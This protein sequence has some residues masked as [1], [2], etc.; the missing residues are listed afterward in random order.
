MT[1]FFKQK[2]GSARAD[3]RRDSNH[4]SDEALNEIEAAGSGRHVCNHQDRYH[5]HASC[6][7]SSQALP[8]DENR[9]SRVSSE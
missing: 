9:V 1:E 8:D 4:G 3:R 2:A 5:S 6:T 7:N